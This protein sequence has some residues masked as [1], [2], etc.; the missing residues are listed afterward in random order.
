MGKYITKKGITLNDV[1]III[2]VIIVIF[3]F[4]FKP[5]IAM[6]DFSVLDRSVKKVESLLSEA[7]NLA[8]SGSSYGVHIE[9]N[10]A[11]LFKGRD[12]DAFNTNNKIKELNHGVIISEAKN[13]IFFDKFTGETKQSGKIKFIL[14]SS[15]SKF[16]ILTVF[17]NGNFFSE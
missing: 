1:V 4:G 5:F 8:I 15:P 16:K 6:K 10:K 13:N 3:L 12:Y 14:V 9:K 2:S 11:V 7:K 17:P